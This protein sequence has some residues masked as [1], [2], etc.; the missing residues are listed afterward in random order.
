MS[1]YVNLSPSSACW[2]CCA[3]GGSEGGESSAWGYHAPAVDGRDSGHGASWGE[4]HWHLDVAADDGVSPAY[5]V[6][7][8]GAW[9]DGIVR[10]RDVESGRQEGR[11]LSPEISENEGK[12]IMLYNDYI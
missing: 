12:H 1:W 4:A 10:A 6:A 3:V 7:A 2:T 9:A 8:A 5:D 11:A